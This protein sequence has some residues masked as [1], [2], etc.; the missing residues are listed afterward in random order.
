MEILQCRST[1]KKT[2]RSVSSEGGTLNKLKTSHTIYMSR[3]R[4]MRGL[5]SENNLRIESS[6]SDN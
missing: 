1:E 2:H 6:V 3:D 4:T 5:S